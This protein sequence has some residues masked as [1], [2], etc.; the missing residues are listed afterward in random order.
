MNKESIVLWILFI[1]QLV[2]I[3]ISIKEWGEIIPEKKGKGFSVFIGI[4]F[5]LL[6]SWALFW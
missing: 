5:A 6:L 1:V 2:G 4:A 3:G